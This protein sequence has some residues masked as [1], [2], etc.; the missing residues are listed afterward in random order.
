MRPRNP[1]T[2]MWAEALEMLEQADRLQRQFFQLSQRSAGACWEPPLD[3][4]DT[5][6]RLYI[7]VALPGVAPD[8]LQVVTDGHMLHVIGDRPMPAV[9]GASIKR[10]EIPYGRFERHIELPA[11][12]L[13]VERQELENGCLRLVLRK[14]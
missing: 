8:K 14:L 12:R 11:G 9:P 7:L 5:E 1:A 10:M 6:Q 2:R 13:E 4:M 3:I